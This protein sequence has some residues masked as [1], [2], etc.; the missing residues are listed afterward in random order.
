MVEAY[1]FG[2][3]DS[4]N[5]ALGARLQRYEGDVEEIRHPKEDLK[6]AKPGFDEVRDG[7]S[8]A[9]RLDLDKVLDEPS[10]CASLRTLFKWCWYHIEGGDTDRF[11]LRDGVCSPVTGSQLWECCGSGGNG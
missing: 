9:K 1:Y 7:L 6:E 10:T 3:I 4:V 11:W 2:D 5:E 8:I